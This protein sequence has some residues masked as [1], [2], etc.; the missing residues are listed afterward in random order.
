[1]L[2]KVAE[3]L[4][5]LFAF[6]LFVWLLGHGLILL[7]GEGITRASEVVGGLAILFILAGWIYIRRCE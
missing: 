3:L 6:L 4:R 2:K 7:Y 1:M 5:K